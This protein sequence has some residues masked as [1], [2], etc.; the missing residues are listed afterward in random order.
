[1]IDLSLACARTW[2][3][4]E[5]AITYWLDECPSNDAREGPYKTRQA[6]HKLVFASLEEMDRLLDDASKPNKPA[7]LM[8]CA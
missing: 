6:C 4:S 7:G 1:V 3:S 2:D 5:R 8:S